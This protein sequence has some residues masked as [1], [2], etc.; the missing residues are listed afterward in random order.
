MDSK[1]QETNFEIAVRLDPSNKLQI[2]MGGSDF[3]AIFPFNKNFPIVGNNF[4]CFTNA[5]IISDNSWHILSISFQSQSLLTVYLDGFNVA[6]VSNFG[7]VYPLFGGTSLYLG[8]GSNLGMLNGK[9]FRGNIMD[10][11]VWNYSIGIQ[12]VR[13]RMKW[14][15]AFSPFSYANGLISLWML[16]EGNGLNIFDLSGNSPGFALNSS[17]AREG[18]FCFYLFISIKISIFRQLFQFFRHMEMTPIPLVLI[19]QF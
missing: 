11:R 15:S 3:K 13:S 6:S 4:Y 2:L 14:R 10:V 9:H 7:P 12:E 8:S 16:E 17:W 1:I 19:F 5:S 18:N